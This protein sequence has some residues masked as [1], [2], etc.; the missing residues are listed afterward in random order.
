MVFSAEA[1]NNP[2]QAMDIREVGGK[3]YGSSHGPYGYVGP[4]A[5]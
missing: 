4:E 2:Y 5:F 3:T 1:V